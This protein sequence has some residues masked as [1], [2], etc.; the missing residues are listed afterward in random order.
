M[1]PLLIDQKPKE[2]NEVGDESRPPT[3]LT[4]HG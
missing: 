1:G 2:Y 4:N 3:H